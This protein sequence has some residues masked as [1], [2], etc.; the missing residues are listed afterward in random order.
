M[1]NSTLR[2]LLAILLATLGLT[3]VSADFGEKATAKLGDPAAPLSVSEWIRGGPVQIEKGTIYAIEFWGTW[4]P[5]SSMAIP[6][7]NELQQLFPNVNFIAI[8]MGELDEIRAY[9]EKKNDEMGYIVAL[10][11]DKQ[12]IAAYLWAYDIDPPLCL[13]IVDTDS[14]VVWHGKPDDEDLPGVLQSVQNGTFDQ[15]TTF[16]KVE[17]KQRREKANFEFF[18]AIMNQGEALENL[19][20]TEPLDLPAIESCLNE[21]L[22][23]IQSAMSSFATESEIQNMYERLMSG[24]Y[25][26][27]NAR[28]LQ[29]DQELRAKTAI[30]QLLTE[31]TFTPVGLVQVN[32]PY[33]FVDSTSHYDPVFGLVHAQYV[34]NNLPVSAS[35]E[36]K[37]TALSTL[38]NALQLNGRTAEALSIQEQAVEI[39]PMDDE[40]KKTLQSY[41]DALVKEEHGLVP[42]E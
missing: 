19:L 11:K 23:V 6:R 39:S 41:R 35:N 31:S 15:D 7:M 37:S 10:D 5:Y 3:C 20:N 22:P 29:P 25:Q 16:R 1:N 42:A 13:F 27:L 8:T 14:R 17:V 26:M 2:Q 36:E 34:A 9:V 40:L 12:T 38:A 24:A 33:Y 30:T 21:R 18:M 28:S 4:D 32:T